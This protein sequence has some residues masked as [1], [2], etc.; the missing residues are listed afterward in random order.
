MNDDE[1]P[2]ECGGELGGTSTDPAT[3]ASAGTPAQRIRLGGIDDY[4]GYMLFTGPGTYQL[5]ATSD[6]QPVGEAIVG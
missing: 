6:G 5:V 4:T 1:K 3:L 2:G